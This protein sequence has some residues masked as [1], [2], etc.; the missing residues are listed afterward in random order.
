LR[1]PEKWLRIGAA[2]GLGQLGDRRAVP[3]LIETLKDG[4]AQVRRHAARALGMLGDD[5]AA[6][7]LYALENDPDKS[8]RDEVALALK[9]LRHREDVKT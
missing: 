2:T 6:E 4:I 7:P 3:A 9:K 5:S 8:V 1:S